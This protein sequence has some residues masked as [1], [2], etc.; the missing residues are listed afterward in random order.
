MQS[1]EGLGDNDDCSVDLLDQL[2]PYLVVRATGKIRSFDFAS[3]ENSS[4]GNV[5]VSLDGLLGSQVMLNC[6]ASIHPASDGPC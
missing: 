5:H 1:N 3:S 6:G 4:K 2:M